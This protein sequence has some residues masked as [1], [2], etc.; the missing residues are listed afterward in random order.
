LARHQL[1]PPDTPLTS[2][3]SVAPQLSAYP[4]RVEPVVVA[5]RIV[6]SRGAGTAIA[7]ALELVRI[8]RGD[9]AAAEVA[10]SIVLP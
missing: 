4:Y 5:D 10:Q 2:H 6:T 1:I 9:T 7:F 3:P 8:L